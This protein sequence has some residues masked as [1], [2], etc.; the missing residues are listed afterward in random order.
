MRSISQIKQIVQLVLLG[1]TLVAFASCTG[2][3]MGQS[4]NGD[5]SVITQEQI[6]EAGTMSS[7]YSI[8]QRLR[9]TW[10]QKRGPSSVS[11]QGSIIVYVDGNRY[12]SPSSLRQIDVVDVESMEYLSDNEATTRFGS[13]HDSGVILVYLKGN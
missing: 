4:S 1:A 13:G 2:S 8:V 5:P 7:A 9:P 10:L 11:S 12:G 6:Q 3:K